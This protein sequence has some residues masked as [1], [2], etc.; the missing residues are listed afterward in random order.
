ML[1]TTVGDSRV[2]LFH[3]L[4]AKP[5]MIHRTWLL[6]DMESHE[7][8]YSLQTNQQTKKITYF[9]FYRERLYYRVTTSLLLLPTKSHFSVRTSWERKCSDADYPCRGTLGKTLDTDLLGEGVYRTRVGGWERLWRRM[10]NILTSDLIFLQ[11]RDGAYQV[12]SD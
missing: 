8:R 3:V 7:T 9:L 1:L 10:P 11:C 6:A 2:V 12:F 4:K 5:D